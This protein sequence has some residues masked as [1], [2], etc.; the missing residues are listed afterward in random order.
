MGWS[1]KW[2]IN[3]N[4][5]G[6]LVI[7]S[8]AL[9]VIINDIMIQTNTPG[10]QMEPLVLEVRPCFGV[11]T[12]KNRGHWGSRYQYFNTT[13]YKCKEIWIKWA[14]LSNCV[15]ET[16]ALKIY[17]IYLN[18]HQ[19]HPKLKPQKSIHLCPL[20]ESNLSWNSSGILSNMVPASCSASNRP[21]R[22]SSTVK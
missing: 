18:L 4:Q 20:R 1:S 17:L 11:L 6:H 5:L 9:E 22:T 3:G 21:P 12:F 13:Q 19:L 10:T 8:T 7:S 15:E 16:H 14:A 2:G